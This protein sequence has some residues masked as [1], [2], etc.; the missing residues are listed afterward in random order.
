MQIQLGSI[1]KRVNSTKNDASFS[2]FNGTLKE[3]CSII[4]PVI[5][6][7]F[8]NASPTGYN[9]MYIPDFRRFY[10]LTWEFRGSAHWYARGKVDV[11]A[12][13]KGE[14]GTASKYVL[15]SSAEENE[16]IV[17]TK[18]PALTTGSYAYAA[19]NPSD[20][21]TNPATQGTYVVGV[22]GDYGG[23]T[24]KTGVTYYALNPG[25]F[26][27]MMNYI[28]SSN[29][30]P[31]SR[32][33]NNFNLNIDFKSNAQVIPWKLMVNP[34][35][36]I[37]SAIWLPFEGVYWSTNAPI[38]FGW[39]TMNING[40]IVSQATRNF[41]YY[42]DCSNLF[43][44][45]A[46]KK[47]WEFFEP[48]S[49]YYINIPFFG[50]QKVAAIDLMGYGAGSAGISVDYQIDVRTGA[51]VCT[52]T[53]A[54]GDCMKLSGQI[55]APIA[56]GGAKKDYGA[57]IGGI[58]STVSSVLSTGMMAASGNPQAIL[59][60]LETIRNGVNTALT[61]CQPVVSSSGAAGGVA[62]VGDAIFVFRK[63]LDCAEKNNAEFGAPLCKVKTLA[64]IPGFIQCSDGDLE[65]SL[66]AD[67][68]LEIARYLTEGFFYE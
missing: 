27:D 26:Q 9:Y 25:T 62:G 41:G 19:A 56:L 24:G 17:D 51:A 35:Q 15:R 65:S 63:S 16:D 54:Q 60:G 67:E 28:F 7:N 32:D 36:Y 6:F 52:V 14:I 22:I 33:W 66:S 3:N 39:F 34:L 49:N 1:R 55:G 30:M 61:T 47:K 59:S 58:A 43:T 68:Q 12:S 38:S 29:S 5:E 11:L 4:D 44:A 46:G 40:N 42:C 45:A 10:F 53:G 8:G 37:T 31:T 21:V 23:S 20:F 2:T 64:S 13:A 18:Y 57:L 50:M 48:W